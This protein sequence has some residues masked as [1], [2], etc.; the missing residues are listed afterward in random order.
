[1]RHGLIT[2]NYKENL[3]SLYSPP[4]ENEVKVALLGRPYTVL[5]NSMNKG[6]PDYFAQLGIKTFFNDSLPTIAKDGDMELLM[7]QFHW[8]YPAAILEAADL[9]VKT[10]GLYPVFVTSFKCAPDSFALE[11]FKRIMDAHEKPY[12]IL[13]LDEHDSN[14][15]YETRIE[16]GVRAFRNHLKSTENRALPEKKYPVN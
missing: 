1:M 9:C 7:D 11:Y 15:G 10:P 4:E 16:A 5:S 6:I 2:N 13:Q 14:V 3:T 12:L 8:A